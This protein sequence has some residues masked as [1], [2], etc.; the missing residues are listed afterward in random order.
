MKPG[1]A[2]KTSN[3]VGREV[4]S[5]DLVEPM[6]MT[7]TVTNVMYSI[8]I[9]SKYPERA[10][11]YLNLLYSD[12]EIINLLTYGEEGID[13]VL[14]KDGIVEFPSGITPDNAKYNPGWGWLIGNQFLSY[15]QS[16]DTKDIWERQKTFNDNAKKSDVYGFMF[17]PRNVSTEITAVENVKRQY[18]NAIGNGDFNPNDIIPRFLR[19]LENAGMDKIIAE[20]QKQLDAW[21]AGK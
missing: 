11:M 4:I 14:N 13:Y 18:E 2:E 7:T 20:K 6:A 12:P 8:P 15:V 19:D 21:Y 17:D 3:I 5:V 1:Y 16:P 10:A 9:N